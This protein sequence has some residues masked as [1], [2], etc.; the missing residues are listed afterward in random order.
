M[1]LKVGGTNQFWLFKDG[2]TIVKQKSSRDKT[3]K[4]L[5]KFEDASLEYCLKRNTMPYREI[6]AT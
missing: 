4:N 1:T 3:L 5:P 6:M 2:F